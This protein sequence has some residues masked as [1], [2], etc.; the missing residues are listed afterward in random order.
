MFLDPNHLD[1]YSPQEMINAAAK[2]HI[3]VDHR[4]IRAILDR[5]EEGRKAVLEFAGRDREEDRIDLAPE[6]NSFFRHWKT[7]DGVPF[8]IRYIEDDPENVPDEAV[9]TLVEVGTPAL[10]PLLALY[11]RLDESE[12]GEVA[13]ILANLRIRDDRI[14]KILKDRLDFDLS[15]TLLLVSIYGDPAAV[16]ALDAALQQIGDSDDALA[17][18][19]RS[20]REQLLASSGIPEPSLDQPFD[21]WQEYPETADIPIDLLDD[22]ERLDLL[23]NGVEAVR[24][25]AAN[26][27]F[28][29]D[30]TEGQRSRLLSVAE[31]DESAR[32]RARAWEALTTATENSQVLE[33]MLTALRRSEMPVEERG[34]LL[35]GLASEADRNE[36]RAAIEALYRVPEGRAKALEAMWRSVHPS[37]REYFPKHLTDAEREVR[38]SAVWGVGY[39]GI[40]SELEKLRK[41]FTDEE[42]RAD[43]LF[44][45]ALATPAE[46]SKG[47][48]KALLSR[49]EKEAQGLSEMEEELV[50]AALDERLMLAGKEPFFAQE[51]D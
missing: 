46:V 25:A 9:E 36:V 28:N 38:R 31:R 42:L 49:I 6:L 10:E 11:D 48:M 40:K 44:A 29:R 50:K 39:Y 5:G 4:F 27:F 23:E 51:E 47:R 32:V 20:V 12:S 26:S 35:V 3:G 30:L 2:G 37:F 24:A 41:L 22:D 8:L 18:E 7:A 45:Y 21:I 43:A 13:F 17:K 1:Q 14:L 34:G 19:V 33:A 15:D 16:P